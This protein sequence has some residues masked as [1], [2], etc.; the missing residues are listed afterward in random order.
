MGVR[1]MVWVVGEGVDGEVVVVVVVGGG[2][3]WLELIGV[4]VQ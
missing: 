2:G 1:G 4:R 3:L